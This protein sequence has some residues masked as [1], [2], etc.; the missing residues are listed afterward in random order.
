MSRIHPVERNA[1]STTRELFAAVEKKLGIVPNLVS[2]MANSPVVAQAYLGFSQTLSGGLL[3]APLRE[4]IALTVGETNQ[5]DYC[6]AAHCF[7]GS[8]AGLSES[9]LA[10]ARHGS[11]SDEK[12]NAALVFARKIVEDRGHVTDEDV[13]EVRQVG[14]SDGEIAEIVANVALNIFTNYFNH[15][16]DT[17]VDFP[18][19]PSLAT[20]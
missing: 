13:E 19:V 18:S 15:V 1:N 2:T 16:A 9:E 8:K 6:V 12:T 4:Q 11:A 17:E 7:L 3:P 20:A 10:E 14:Y 5:C